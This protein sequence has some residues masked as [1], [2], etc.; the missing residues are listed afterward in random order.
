[1]CE[2]LNMVS[3]EELATRQLDAYNQ[4]DLMAF[5]DCYHS[6]VVVCNNQEES[7]R[8]RDELRER[9]RSMFEGWKFGAMV[10]KRIALGGHC[11][12]LEHWWRVDPETS[13]RNEGELLVRY[14][15]REGLIG[16]VQFL[17]PD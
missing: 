7:Y 12:D 11:I 8:G 5:A 14:S 3:I 9:Y 2:D 17:R 4:A 15:I 16:W 13:E 10:S 6:E 1:I